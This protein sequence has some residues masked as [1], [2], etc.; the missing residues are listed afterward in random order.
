MIV[1]FSFQEEMEK[2]SDVS[3]EDVAEPEE[4][5]ECQQALQGTAH[6]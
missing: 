4:K 2:T 6:V 5:L 3:E 1:A